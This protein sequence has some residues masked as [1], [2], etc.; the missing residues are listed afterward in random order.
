M[1]NSF[2]RIAERLHKDPT[3][4]S[5]EV[6]KNAKEIKGHYTHSRCSKCKHF[7]S[8][9][10]RG[11]DLAAKACPRSSY[12]SNL[13]KRCYRE[14]PYMT[15]SLHIPFK[16]ERLSKPP[17]VCN[18]CDEEKLCPITHRLYQAS[19]AQIQ[20]FM[21]CKF[22]PVNFLHHIIHFTHGIHFFYKLLW[23]DDDLM[24]T[25]WNDHQIIFQEIC[26]TF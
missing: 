26:N 5:K 10:I 17:Y 13:C 3:T 18:S 14:K 4:I 9:D 1:G 16:C 6:R 11:T 2:K 19:S 7:R 20:Y 21:L 22:C 15:C 24:D 23:N 12:C 8:C 25:A